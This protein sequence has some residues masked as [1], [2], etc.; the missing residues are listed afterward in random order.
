MSS[1]ADGILGLY[2]AV[3]D[4]L[5]GRRIGFA[6][7][8]AAVAARFARHRKAGDA[9]VAASWTAGLLAEAG[10]LGVV[11]TDPNDRA[12]LFALADAPLHGA[13]LAAAIPGLPAG[14]ADMIRWHR[15]HDDGTGFPD[16]LRWDGIPAD[17]ASLGIAHAFLEALEDPA[18]PRGAAEAL[19]TILAENG[20]RFRVEL[21]RAFREFV[22][23][24]PD[25][26]D[27]AVELDLP[28]LD[29]GAL[30]AAL[31]QRLDA[32]AAR[33]DGRSARLAA[34]AGGVAER[35]GDDPGRA[36]RLARLVALGRA[37]ADPGDNAFDPLSRFA[38]EQRGVEARRASGLA[39]AI[40][41][42]AADAAALAASAAWYEDGGSDRYAATLALALVVDELG[43]LEAPRLVAAAAGTQFDP[44]IVRAYLAGAGAPT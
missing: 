18:E 42:F 35:L 22:A 27:A 12:A 17:A 40:P 19:F 7:R 29:D 6:R 11:V 20:R 8:R 39:A 36:A 41:A 37:A 13:R 30:L 31:A 10:H 15:E 43:P 4:A 9:A 21:V 3:G 33:T 44:E 38:R 16:R 14:T 26:W 5:A 34:I 32:R 1:P 23:S 24:A 25:G 2:G 28:G